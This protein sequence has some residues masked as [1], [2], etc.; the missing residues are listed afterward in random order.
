MPHH[1]TVSQGRG[2]WMFRNKRQQ[3]KRTCFFHCSEAASWPSH[4]TY[5]HMYPHFLRSFL[6]IFSL[7]TYIYLHFLY[8]F[9]CLLQLNHVLKDE[10]ELLLIPCTIYTKPPCPM[11]GVS[12]FSIF[13]NWLVHASTSSSYYNIYNI[14]HLLTN[15][16]TESLETTANTPLSAAGE[17]LMKASFIR[18]QEKRS[19]AKRAGPCVIW[20]ICP[21]MV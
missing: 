13:P 14:Q 7:L 5:L 20:Q 1:C 12:Y 10:G 18:P 6:W 15:Q 3:L 2:R 17:D 16:A 9:V 11:Y 19:W 21:N 4:Y 8:D